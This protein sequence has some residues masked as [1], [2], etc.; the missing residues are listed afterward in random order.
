MYSD[1]MF[2]SLTYFKC[3]ELSNA[4]ESFWIL[5]KKYEIPPPKKEKEELFGKNYVPNQMRVK[6]VLITKNCN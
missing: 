6:P 2:W 4:L 5:L 3:L 1:E